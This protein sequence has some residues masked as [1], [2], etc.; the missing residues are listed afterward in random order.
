VASPPIVVIVV[1]AVGAAVA[2]RRLPGER[3]IALSAIIASVNFSAVGAALAGDQLLQ[4]A[5]I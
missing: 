4:L 2:A 3:A 5:A 1:V